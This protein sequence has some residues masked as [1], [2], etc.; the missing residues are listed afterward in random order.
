MALIQKKKETTV[1]QDYEKLRNRID[2]AVNRHRPN[3]LLNAPTGFG[4]GLVAIFLDL[5]K[6]L[7]DEATKGMS[8]KAVDQA[9]DYAIAELE[10]L[11]VELN[12][13]EMIRLSLTL[14]ELSNTVGNRE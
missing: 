6:I 12:Q 2:K 9:N 1:S 11:T 14:A 10:G 7:S 5:A 8:E 13:R 4:L 3:L